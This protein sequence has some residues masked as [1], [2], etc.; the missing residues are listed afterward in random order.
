MNATPT[1]VTTRGEQAKKTL[2]AAALAQFGEYGLHAT[3]RDIAALAGQNIAAI[4]YYFGSKEE[5]YMA[6]A[7]WIA[8]F[9]TQNFK[10]H[11]ERAEA[12][13]NQPQTDKSQ[14]RQLI[15]TACNHMIILLTADETLNLSKFIS[16]EQLSPTPAYQLIHQQVIA[17]MH[18]HLTR[19]I[20]RYT[21]HCPDDTEMILH[22]HALIG[23]VLAFRLGRETILLRAG[24]TTFDNEKVK[25]ISDVVSSHVDFILQGLASQQGNS[26]NEK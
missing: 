16:R 12:I 21:G 17:P 15:H 8:D 10:P 25:K 14:I 26:G 9:I 13:L 18:T 1:P 24:W 22:T 19:L 4:T 2:I 23:Q 3:T 6:C 7:Q 5:L 11:V 20:G